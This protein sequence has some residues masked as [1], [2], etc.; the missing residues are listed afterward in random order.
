MTYSGYSFNLHLHLVLSALGHV[1]TEPVEASTVQSK[2][3]PTEP[4]ALYFHF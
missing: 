1:G 3:S 4:Q 2:H